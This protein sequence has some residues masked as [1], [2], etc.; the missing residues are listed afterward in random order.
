MKYWPTSM[1]IRSPALS[2]IQKREVLRMDFY[3]ISPPFSTLALCR[4]VAFTLPA[5]TS[6]LPMYTEGCTVKLT[7]L[8]RPTQEDWLHLERSGFLAIADDFGFTKETLH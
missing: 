3:R 5:H 7:Y 8:S 2:R 4:G 6:L 1:L